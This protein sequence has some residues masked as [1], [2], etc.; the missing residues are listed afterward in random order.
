LMAPMAAFQTLPSVGVFRATQLQV[1]GIQMQAINVAVNSSGREVVIKPTAELY[2]GSV[3]ANLRYQ[4][5]DTGG[6]LKVVSEF[7]DV[8]MGPLLR[9]AQISDQLVGKGFIRTDLLFSEVNGKFSQSGSINLQALDGAISG[10]GISQ[11][12]DRLNQNLSEKCKEFREKYFLLTK[13]INER[14]RDWSDRLQSYR[15]DNDGSG[16]DKLIFTKS[17]ADIQL[18]NFILNNRSLVIEAEK[19]FIRGRG[20]I[21]TRSQALDYQVTLDPVDLRSNNNEALPLSIPFAAKGKLPEIKF[22]PDYRLFFENLTEE[23]KNLEK[24]RLREK[25]QD[26]L[27]IGESGADDSSQSTGKQLQEDLKKK[28]LDKLFR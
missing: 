8:E 20:S 9:D 26:K 1:G 10:A 14:C 13:K 7:R 16:E 23:L 21:D 17:N 6:Q 15:S 12:I 4:P 25:L 22:A 24:R 3:S 27:G 28:L 19:F 11:M 5:E 2:R 18:D